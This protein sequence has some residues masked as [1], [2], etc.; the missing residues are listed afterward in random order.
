MM[1]KRIERIA[2]IS[3]RLSRWSRASLTG[4]AYAESPDER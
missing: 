2:I 3:A 1:D 4:I